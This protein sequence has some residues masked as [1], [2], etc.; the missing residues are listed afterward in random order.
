MFGAMGPLV[1][2][3]VLGAFSSIAAPETRRRTLLLLSF[4]AAFL[5]FIFSTYPAS[6]YLV[7]LA[8]FI[9]VFAAVAFVRAFRMDKLTRAGSAFGLALIV[10]VAAGESLWT[11]LFIR[12]TDTRTLAAR[13]IEANVPEAATVLTQ[14]YS[15]PLTATADVLREAVARNR[16]EMP[17]KTALELER[18]PY[19]A[20]AYRLLYLGRGLDADKIYV[21]YDGLGAETEDN[22][23]RA[24]HVA[25]VLLKRYNGVDPGTLPLLKTLAREARRVAVFSPYREGAEIGAGSRPEPFLHNTDAR[26]DAALERPGPI[27]EI[28]QIH[29]PGS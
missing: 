1:L 13:Y 26:I 29:G 15:V 25:F 10:F 24:E 17:K 6:R 5:L 18:S 2:V 14:P 22:P 7:P 28:W 8:P 16:R 11:D 3:S 20:P 12:Q 19:P 23:I 27:V 9:A 4:P 21:Q